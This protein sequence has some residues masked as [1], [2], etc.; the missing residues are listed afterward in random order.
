VAGALFAALI[1]VAAMTTLQATP[2][3]PGVLRPQDAAVRIGQHVTVEGTVWVHVKGRATFLDMGGDYPN[4]ALAVVIWPE[5]EGQFGNVTAFDGK[6]IAV[7]GVIQMFNGV[8]EIVIH[9]KSQL[10]AR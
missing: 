1:A 10:R 8:P 6:T 3:A 9:Q 5:D 2:F 4:Q 7:S